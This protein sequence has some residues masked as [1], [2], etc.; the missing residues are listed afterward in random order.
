MIVNQDN[1]FKNSLSQDFN[2]KKTLS[3][4]F[5]QW[6]W[7]V[8][9]CLLCLCIA[10]TYLR[11]TRPSYEAYA[12]IMLLDDKDN[13]SPSAVFQD[14][15][16]FS[17]SEEAK[18]ED[19]IQIIRSR[20]L[21]RSVVKKLKLNLRYY[22]KGRVY[23]SELYGNGIPVNF[24]FIAS[25]SIIN[26]T[27]SEF[28]IDINSSVGFNYR[29]N[30]SD[31]PKKY[32]F[33]ENIPTS[34]GGLIITPKNSDT[35]KLIGYDLRVSMSSV[36]YVAEI[37]RQNIS[38]EP[39]GKSSKVLIVS[40]TNNLS[41]KAKDIVS[42]LIEE[43]NYSTLKLKNS[44][45]KNTAEFID[46][47]VELIASDL[48]N[49]DDS[50]VRFKTG[51][52]ITDVSSEAGQ[53]LSS[54]T[55][56]EQLLDQA[57][58][59]YRV[60]SYMKETLDT[61]SSK[62]EPI[63]SLGTSD[64]SINA[65]S[66]RYSE[67][68]ANRERLLTSAGEKNLVIVQLDESLNAIRQNLEQSIDNAKKTLNIRINGLQSQSDR[69][70]SKIYSVPGQESKLRGIERKQGI[71]EALYLYL[72]QK[73]EEATISMT[74][75]SPSVKVVDEAFSTGVPVSPN[76]QV[77]YIAA[78]FIGLFLPFSVIYVNDLLDNK[79]HNKED[80]EKII[81]DITVLGELPRLKGKDL[82]SLVQ[83]N[84]RSL[85][86]ESFRIIRTNF[87]YVRRGRQVKEYDNVIFVTST[88]NG[89]GKSFFSV[90]FALTLANTDKRVLLIGADIRNP[91]TDLGT[92]NQNKKRVSK[93]GLTE[94]LIDDSILIGEAIDT[95]DV[96]ENKIDVLLSGKVPPN[97][98]ELL[99]SDRMKPLF[100]KVSNQYDFVIVDTAPAMLVTDTLLFSQFAGHTIYLTRADYTEKE[101]LNFAKDLHSK[102]KL[103][104]MMLVVNDVNQ[105]NFGYGARY[106][107][108]GAPEK[109]SIIKRFLGD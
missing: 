91:K 8:I 108:Y 15:S 4:Y 66:A 1:S 109:K 106:G 2:L 64:P 36:N 51:N 60:L 39:Y 30:E 50:I 94:Y 22:T 88:I 47:R 41:Q 99:M 103:N 45:S 16:L 33:G 107:Y 87:D 43:Y 79:I 67:L 32:A 6:R 75:T 104:G 76:S 63:P 18:V 3:L 19:Q 59:E 12:K 62:F 57:Q 7:F 100:D 28:F 25:D 73:R 90:N 9:S 46:S 65:L 105:S 27:N 80:L 69:I 52:K 24:N 38:V 101:I 5:K 78:L 86:S 102:N 11:Y 58:T 35:E 68:L 20:D 96:G 26:K 55:Q 48:V 23:E 97:P 10:F 56:N 92:L 61:D 49:V 85:L 93:I 84:D 74:A 21:I 37:I 13:S 77:I 54:S 70:N 82:D 98:A 40:A 31:T 42:T 14:L 95:Y 71:K 29:A 83:R 44:R 53:F 81:N 17:E 34:F 72:L 89:E